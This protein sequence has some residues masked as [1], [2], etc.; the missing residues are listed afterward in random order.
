MGALNEWSQGEFGKSM[1][2]GREEIWKW[3][4]TTISGNPLFGT[5]FV[6]SGN[7]HN[8]AVA[9][10]VAYGIVGYG[11]W[12]GLFEV[13]LNKTLAW[14]NDICVAGA[15]SAFFVIFWQQSV[16]LGMF[17]GSPNIIP[18]AIMGILLARVKMLK[19]QECQELV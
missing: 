14:W 11:L 19:E 15:I 7:Y 13:M 18:Y 1:F 8:S 10:L 9:C 6:D 2:S 16:E 5:G 4:F 12:I 17:S 3:A